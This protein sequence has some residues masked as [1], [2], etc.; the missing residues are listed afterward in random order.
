MTTGA[1]EPAPTQSATSADATW[2]PYPVQ[3]PERNE[4]WR[5]HARIMRYGAPLTGRPDPISLELKPPWFRG[6][7]AGIV[8]LLCVVLASMTLP[9]GGLVGWLLVLLAVVT[10]GVTARTLALRR[11]QAGLTV[12]G[13]GITVR[14]GV[15]VT[16]VA[17]DDLH[18]VQLGPYARKG[19][20]ESTGVALRLKPKR[21]RPA[22]APLTDVDTVQV[23]VKEGFGRRPLG[24]RSRCC[25]YSWQK[26]FL[27]GKSVGIHSD[28]IVIDAGVKTSSRRCVTTGAQRDKQG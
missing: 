25:W 7:G 27:T 19:Q 8:S 13:E 24:C 4:A 1:A 3:E 28:H 18:A 14:S 22:P 15:G 9:S 21:P 12:S 5:N 11:R 26:S 23:N 10:G 6:L 16:Q 20:D 2:A 17:W